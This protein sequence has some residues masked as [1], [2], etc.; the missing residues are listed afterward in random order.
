MSG[1]KVDNANFIHIDDLK[2]IKDD[3][4]YRRLLEEFPYWLNQAKEMKIVT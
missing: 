3:E 2:N 1:R 4:L